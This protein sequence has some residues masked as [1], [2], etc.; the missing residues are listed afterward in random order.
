MNERREIALRIIKNHSRKLARFEHIRKFV[1]LHSNMEFTAE[2]FYSQFSDLKEYV[3]LKNVAKEMDAA[4]NDLHQ[5]Y[6]EVIELFF[7]LPGKPGRLRLLMM[8]DS[9][10]QR[11]LLQIDGEVFFEKRVDLR[12]V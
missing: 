10:F 11:I 6:L 7:V 3:N 12:Q 1:F 8:L 9:D 4:W 2:K 5:K